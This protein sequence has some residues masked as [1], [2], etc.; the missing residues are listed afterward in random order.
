M[1]AVAVFPATRAVTLIDHASPRIDTPTQV[2]LRMLDVGL[3][4]IDRE[5]CALQYGTPPQGCAYL[6]IGHESL[7][8]VIDVGSGVSRV[9]VGDLAV[10]GVRRPCPHD[11]CV[12]CR[13]GRQDFCYTGGFTE[14]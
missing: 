13:A 6:V 1:K 5:I 7:G 9:T 11:A 8:E 3:C 14:R 2:K 12:A 10:L 4:G